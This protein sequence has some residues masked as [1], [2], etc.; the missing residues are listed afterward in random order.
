MGFRITGIDTPYGGIN[1]ENCKSN[2][3]YI[4]H[5]FL[6]FESKRLLVNS[7]EMEKKDWC[8]QY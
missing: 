8:I 5:L 4:K 1:W 6:Y 3:D 7:K 2:K